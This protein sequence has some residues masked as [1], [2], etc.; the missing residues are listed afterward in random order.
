[1]SMEA[2]DIE[3]WARE[4][5]AGEIHNGSLVLWQS[6][7]TRFA[8]LVEAAA[9]EKAAKIVMDERV[10]HECTQSVEDEAYNRALTHACDAI[11]STAKKEAGEPL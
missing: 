5:G 8:A 6:Q 2:A 7:F 1:M 10:D 11:R 3:R 9:M 4:A